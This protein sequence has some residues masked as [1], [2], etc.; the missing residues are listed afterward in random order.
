MYNAMGIEMRRT[1]VYHPQANGQD[2]NTNKNLK[3]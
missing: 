1:A 3:R 2:E